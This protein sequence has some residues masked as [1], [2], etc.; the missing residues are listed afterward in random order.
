MDSNLPQSGHDPSSEAPQEPAEPRA[1]RRW[2]RISTWI[3][4]GL[5]AVLLLI[6]ATTAIVVRSA[7]FHNYVLSM[8]QKQASA[9]M[10]DHP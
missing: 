5:A 7:Q 9:A 2:L 1:R 8:L 4:C 6:V 10:Q 3:V